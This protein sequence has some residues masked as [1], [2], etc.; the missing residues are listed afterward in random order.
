MTASGTGPAHAERIAGV[1]LGTAIGDALG[2]PREGLSA[3]RA[4]VLFGDELRHA[5]VL[6]R[7]MVSDDTEH[8]CL[9]VQA[10]LASGGDLRRFRR[11]LAWRLR[12]WFVALPAGVGLATA[13]AIVRL[14]CGWPPERSGVRSAGN[15]PAMR[16][17][18]LGLLVDGDD[19]R[20]REWVRAA[21]VLTHTDPR[22]ERAAALVA[23]GVCHGP[24]G[25]TGVARRALPDID[26]ELA[27]I[28]DL[29]DAQLR[30]DADVATFAAALGVGPRGVTGYAY[31]TVPVALYAWLRHPHDVRAALT[32]VID[33]GGD[34]DTVG[35]ITG[36][37]CGASLGDAHLPPD[38]IE[39]IADAP[40]SVTWLRRLAA[41]AAE[42][43]APLG[44]AWPLLPLRNL[45]F[46]VVVL[47]HGFR[48]LLPPY[49]EGAA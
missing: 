34:T 4:R 39:G 12:G 23:L 44:L 1:L 31:R 42:G 49:G 20:L 14:W 25:F 47:A 48:R 18:V 29:V 2:L 43:G 11:S 13:R 8:A 38:W 41:R 17:G 30:L 40:R 37:L 5:L 15:G 24:G 46:L 45:L 33:L 27:R 6:G 3:S 7:G 36:A 32:A 9:V 16:A 19:A 22:A 10:F 35:A 26:D 21:T 28:L